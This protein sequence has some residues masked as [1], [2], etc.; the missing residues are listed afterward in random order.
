MF[1]VKNY[2]L[3]WNKIYILF[4][5]G[6]KTHFGFLA[7]VLIISTWNLFVWVKLEAFCLLGP[8]FMVSKWQDT[9]FFSSSY[10]IIM[11]TLSKIDQNQHFKA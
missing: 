8:I 4:K 11:N 5:M 6:S 7:I 2:L 3:S 9:L 10:H 1:I